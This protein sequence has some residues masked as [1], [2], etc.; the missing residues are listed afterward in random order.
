MI[1]RYTGPE[2]AKIWSD[3]NRFSKWLQI[4]LAA[5][6]AWAKLGR[7]PPDALEKI[8]TKARFDVKR[9]E[10]IEEVTNH[11]VIAFLTCVAENVGEESRFIHMGMTSSDV[12]DT[13]MSLLMRDALDIIID[14]VKTLI[15]VMIERAREHRHTVM[16]G[17]THGVHAEPVTLGLKFALWVSEMRRNLARLEQAR[18]TIAY[19]KISGAVGTY[20]NVDPYVEEYVCQ[21]LGL[22][23]ADISTQI[24]QRDRHAELLTTL[25]IAAGSIEKFATE[26]RSLQRTEIFELQEPFKKGQ[27]GSSAMP[28]KRNPIMC[29]RMVGLARVIRGNAMVALENIALWHERDITHSSAERIIIPDSTILMDYMLRKFTGIVK[30]LVVRPERMKENLER[31]GGLIFSE[32]VLLALVGKGLTREDAYAIVQ[33]NAARAWDEGLNFKEL[34]VND[35][36]VRERLTPQ[37]IE[38]CFDPSHHLKHVDEILGRLGI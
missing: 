9:I 13:A 15:D 11:D 35:P 26:I 5:C 4:E 37:E 7:I 33:S 2:M 34:V 17:R 21:K 14:D 22:S 19:G 10:E 31:T 8:K 12:V 3:E 38:A 28:H 30:G 24:L 23:R 1:P 36:R 32:L 6:E 16:I 20:A 27:K 18:R 25:A 29:E